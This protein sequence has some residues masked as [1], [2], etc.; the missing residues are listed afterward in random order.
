MSSNQLHRRQ[1]LARLF[2]T[3][4][5]RYN[6][7]G[8]PG[9]VK[10]APSGIPPA[11]RPMPRH[12]RR[13]VKRLKPMQKRLRVFVS[14]DYDHDRF[15]AWSFIGQANLA[16]SPFSFANWMLKE[17]APQRDWVKKAIRNINQSHV[18]LV[19]CGDQTYRAPGVRT[20]VTIAR[21]LRKPILQ[22]RG[23]SGANVRPVLPSEP[24]HDR[25]W[26]N[27]MSALRRSTSLLAP[28]RRRVVRAR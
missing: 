3:A 9:S 13:L 10:T 25:D 2:G 23:R 18:L 6:G 8:A 15:L 19:V 22:V 4:Q 26:P 16:T 21:L 20:E 7:V 11:N 27:L 17:A 24:L 1:A 5:R 14:F 28:S 12:P